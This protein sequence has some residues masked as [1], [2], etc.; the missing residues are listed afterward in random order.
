MVSLRRKANASGFRPLCDVAADR[1]HG[2]RM[3]TSF[4][5]FSPEVR[6]KTTTNRQL[7]QITPANVLLG[8]AA[9]IQD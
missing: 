1:R 6:S 3:M 8:A 2:A 5:S 7:A 9:E 4:D